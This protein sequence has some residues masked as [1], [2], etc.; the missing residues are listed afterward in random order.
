MRALLLCAAVVASAPAATAGADT[1]AG[2]PRAEGF[3]RRLDI[4]VL[5][6]PG[7]RVG[8]SELRRQPLWVAYRA[9]A[10]G[11]RPLGPRPEKFAVDP[12]VWR[13]VSSRDY[14]HSGY[15][16]GHLAPNYLIGKLYGREAQRATFLMSNISPQSQRL[17]KLVWQ[18]LEEAEADVVAP[19]AGELWVLAGPV[20]SAAPRRLASGI[21]IPDAF[22]RIWLDVAD[23]GDPRVLAFIVPQE[24]CGTEPLSQYLASV[25]EVE[26]RTRLDFFHELEDGL[27]AAIE[28]ALQPQDWSL[29]RYDRKPPRYADKFGPLNCDIR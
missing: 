25:D 14:W 5:R 2:E 19:R 24:V 1:Y 23:A 21:P 26:R 16:R 28:A 10:A 12:R 27:E 4:K 8:Y 11:T 7:F 18:R 15:D 20:F 9:E 6:N 3:W 13:E 17:N 29:S 22:Y